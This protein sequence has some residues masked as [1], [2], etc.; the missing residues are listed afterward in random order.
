MKVIVIGC[1]GGFLVV[2]E[3]ML[4]YLFQLGDYFL[5]VD[6]GSVVLF[7]LFGYVLVEKLDVVILFYYYYD[8]IVDIGLL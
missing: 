1:Y 3:V 4:G 5:F 6:C 7:K 8:Y 2:N